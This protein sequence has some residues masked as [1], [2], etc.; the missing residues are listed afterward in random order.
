[1]TPVHWTA[2]W[3]SPDAIAVLVEHGASTNITDDKGH[4]P[5]DYAQMLNNEAALRKLEQL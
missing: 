3:N 2:R 1:M 4:K 5:I